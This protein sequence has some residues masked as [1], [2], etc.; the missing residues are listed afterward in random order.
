M[1]SVLELKGKFEQKA[2]SGS[3]GGGRNMPSGKSVKLD[4]VKKLIEDPKF[5]NKYWQEDT[6]VNNAF[7]SVHY[8]DVI[9]K[10]NRLSGLLTNRGKD[11][12]DSVV[13]AKFT[14]GNNEIKHIITQY[15]TL[16]LI[17]ESI[18]RLQVINNIMVNSGVIEITHEHLKNENVEKFQNFYNKFNLSKSAF[19]SILADAY[20][21]ESF[22]VPTNEFNNDK[23]SIITIYKT[24]IKTIDL[25]SKVGIRVT[26]SKIIEETTLLLLPD[27][28]EILRNKAPYL[29]S[30]AITDISEIPKFNFNEV[31]NDTIGIPS[32]QNEPIIGVI[33]TQFDTNVYFSEWVDYTNMITDDIELTSND[34]KHGTAVSSILVDGPNINPE[35]DDGCGRFRVRHFGVAKSGKFSS[36][37]IVKAIKDIIN[38]N[39]DIKVWNL[40]LG[41]NLEINQNFISPEAAL[42]DKIQTEN[43]IIFVIAGTNNNTD[44]KNMLVGAPADS[45]NSLVVNS[46]DYNKNPADYSRVGPVL[47][48]FQKPDISYYGGTKDKPMRVCTP[49]GEGFVV[50]TSFAAPWISRKM[51]Y[52]INVLGFTRE[53]AKAILIHSTTGWDKTSI[54]SMAVGYGVVPIKIED[55]VNSKDDEI[56]FILNGVSEEYNTYIYNLPVPRSEG[57]HPY[58]AKATMCY[59]PYCS[60]NQGVDYTNTEFDLYFGVLK[61]DG[62]GIN[63]VNQNKQSGYENSYTKEV[64]ARKSFRK[65]DNVKYITEYYSN[66]KQMKESNDAGV[67]GISVKTKERLKEKFGEG[68]RF[69]IVITLKELNGVN[70]INEFERLCISKGWIVNKIDVKNRV[71]IYN[72]MEE[73]IDFNELI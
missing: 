63:T 31:E 56:Q 8:C 73:D 70:R 13:G 3:F 65:W 17:N 22:R 28:L 69:G 29:I 64:V 14:E 50:G 37:T 4:K 68:I 7:V 55:I 49:N 53:T 10:S 35:F 11:P 52:L 12:N 30:M 48:F 51:A 26:E 34:Y 67:W 41:S 72:V 6:I 25:L 45:I 46:V 54:D 15:V 62:K 44:K 20:Y 18:R 60:R 58:I 5:L 42:L 16:E 19:Q 9:A 38:S 27:E 39:K 32:P 36:F 57:M 47:S 71:D 40:S 59:F 61:K 66:R 24:D 33:D 23:N 21:V 43:D 2:R 1:N